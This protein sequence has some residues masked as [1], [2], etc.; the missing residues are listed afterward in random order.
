[1]STQ[2]VFM[3]VCAMTCF[4]ALLHAP[5]EVCMA[6]MPSGVCEGVP[7]L[8]PLLLVPLMFGDCTWLMPGGMYGLCA[9]LKGWC[10][11]WWEAKGEEE[12]GLL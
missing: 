3:D 7:G 8:L 1:M 5:S 10:C 2:L 11:W 9:L 6:L 4:D 12:P